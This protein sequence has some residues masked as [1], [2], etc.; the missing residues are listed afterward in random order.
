MRTRYFLILIFFSFFLNHKNL[1]GQLSPGDIAFVQYNSD[2]PDSF[3][4]VALTHIPASTVL[5]FTDNGWITS[6]N[7]FRTGEGIITWTSPTTLISCGTIIFINNADSSSVSSTIGMVNYAG[8][9]NLSTEGDQILAYTGNETSPSFLAAINFANGGWSVDATSANTSAIPP[10][11]TDGTHCLHAG[12]FNN[13]KYNIVSISDEQSDLLTSI[14][15]ALNWIGDDNTLQTYTG[16]ITVTDCPPTSNATDYFRSKTTGPATW[17]S[18]YSWE[19]SADGSTDWI[20][21]TLHPDAE[22]SSVEIQSGHTI[23]INSSG[24]EITNTRVFGILE[25]ITSND[26]SVE[27]D[28]E[29]ELYIE[30]GGNFIVDNADSHPIRNAFGLVKTGG[31]LTAGANA[32]TAF[33]LHDYVSTM[34]G[35]FYFEHASICDW[36]RNAYPSSNSTDYDI[37]DLFHPYPNDSGAMPIF[38]I[39]NLPTG[40]AYGNSNNSNTIYAVLELN[41]TTPFHFQNPT[42]KT[43]VGGIRSAGNIDATVT[44]YANS[45]NL[46][47]GTNASHYFYP[48][49]IPELSGSVAFSMRSAGLRLENGADVTENS[50]IIISSLE[51]TENNSINR[52]GGTL[53][54]NGILDITNMR[55]TNTAAGSISVNEGGTIRT[56]NTGGLFGGGSAIVEEANFTLQD[57]ST[58][59]YYATENQII[60]SG[61]TYYHLIFSGSGI[62]DPQN[63]TDVH[64][65]GSITITGDPV[66]DYSENNLGLTTINN[67]DFSMNGGRLILGT[68]GTLPRPGGT[69]SITGG[70][71]EFTGNSNTSIRVIPDYYDVRISGAD[72]QPGA[73]GFTI[74]H[75]LTVT[76]GGELSI[77]TS[78]DLEPPFVLNALGGITVEPNG[79]LQLE[80][81]AVLIQNPGVS[82][83]GNI[84]QIRNAVV[85]SIQYNF[86][87][88]PVSGQDLYELYP[89]I[90]ANRVMVYNTETDFY[91]IIPDNPS[92]PPE[93]Q[94]GVGYSIKGPSSNFPTNGGGGTAVIATFIGTPHNE[95]S[96]NTENQIPLSTEGQG[97]N[98]IGNPYPSNLD[99]KLLNDE[100]VNSGKIQNASFYFWD[101]T[102]N[103]DLYQQGPDYVNQNFALYNASGTGTGICAPRF[104]TT[105]KKPNGIVKP[106]QGFII[107]ATSIADF[108]EVTNSMRTST[109][110]RNGDYAPYFKNGNATNPN[111]EIPR[112]DQFWLEL[113]NPEGML[114]QTAISYFEEAEDTFEVFDSEILTENASENLYSLSKDGMKLAIQ[115]REGIFHNDDVVPLGV[116]FFVNG[117]YKIQLEETKGIFKNHQDIYL[118]DKYLGAIHNLSDNGYYD[119]EGLE[120]E[121]NDRFEIV[122]QDGSTPSGPVLT[123]ASQN[124]INILKHDNQIEISS[125]RDKIIE[126][127]IFNLSGWSIYKIAQVNQN[128][129]RIPAS[130]L[131]KKNHHRQNRN[132]NRRNPNQ[133]VCQSISKF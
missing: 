97:F 48:S 111:D 24:I 53:N 132:G 103:D 89:D 59:D 82:N 18:V 20:D 73:K 10:G 76:S 106:G 43:I 77:P 87:C 8:S 1:Y 33:F 116:K 98:L 34:N 86:W 57:G 13:G 42:D 62:K 115:G 88:S 102:D 58:V 79:I 121:F 83:S 4:F 36:Q 110:L 127:E 39:S 85:P 75:F 108:I 113:V 80:N 21:A 66:V 19:S 46:V 90:P 125:S 120:G 84:T 5:K 28:D 23:Q 123:T 81:N 64:N 32:H 119:F 101:N 68:G 26:F 11:L 133:K 14:N 130:L 44:Q 128:T 94:F 96:N 16:I 71:I 3:A 112:I 6:T 17:N 74:M 25:L 65:L 69:Y 91:T 30:N 61:K 126:V 12:N 117:K 70:E 54:I 95:S 122:F 67:T 38:R 27:G 41:T 55:I 100:A 104:G 129:L 92:N 51:N 52:A 15:N 47:L 78:T 7:T 31:T 60:S 93:F 118:K 45:G 109:V 63:Q 50:T 124:K 40:Q 114:I 105:G 22:A 2:N 37:A 107:Q 29:I 35:L 131:G 99:L 56:R 9:F 49:A 72:K